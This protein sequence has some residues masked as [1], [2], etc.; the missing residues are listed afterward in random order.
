MLGL[1]GD[2]RGAPFGQVQDVPPRVIP[3]RP[4][5]GLLQGTQGDSLRVVKSLHGGWIFVAVPTPCRTLD[6][7]R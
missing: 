1:P 3:G 5:V 7:G 6:A 4:A 2:Q